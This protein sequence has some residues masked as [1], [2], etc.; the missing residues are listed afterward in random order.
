M[1]TRNRVQDA[2]GSSTDC[3]LGQ[4]LGCGAL[5]DRLLCHVRGRS[6]GLRLQE[7]TLH[8]AVLDGGRDRRGV[9]HRCRGD[10]PPRPVG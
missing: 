2:G 8:L 6:C 4:R 1:L 9:A 3:L 5:D 10:L 7:A